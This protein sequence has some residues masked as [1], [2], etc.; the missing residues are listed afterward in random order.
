MSTGC[1]AERGLR[2]RTCLPVNAAALARTL[3]RAGD[4]RSCVWTGGDWQ[5]PRRDV[6]S[7]WRWFTDADVLATV[8]SFLA[9]RH[10]AR[11]LLSERSVCSS[12]DLWEVLVRQVSHAVCAGGVPSARANLAKMMCM[13]P[14]IWPTDET[15]R[16]YILS[17]GLSNYRWCLDLCY[18]GCSVFSAVVPVTDLSARDLRDSESLHRED[19]GHLR[20]V[21]NLLPLRQ[22]PSSVLGPLRAAWSRRTDPVPHSLQWLRFLERQDEFDRDTMKCSLWLFDTRSREVVA[23]VRRDM[24]YGAY[25]GNFRFYVSEEF[26]WIEDGQ[27]VDAYPDEME[28]YVEGRVLEI[29]VRFRFI[30]I[31]AAAY[32]LSCCVQ[33]WVAD[34]RSVQRIDSHAGDDHDLS[35]PA[36]DRELLWE[37]RRATPWDFMHALGA[38]TLQPAVAQADV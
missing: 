34:G 28:S 29:W 26:Q 36:E 31:A 21:R 15:A 10:L 35:N 27:D 14:C 8:A 20:C 17:G 11:F 38:C 2:R 6:N 24:S 25:T 13:T 18:R 4:A 16:G 23:T 7:L 3:P 37:R 33:T 19:S 1:G 30:P 22:L 5:S 9:V 32:Q 12:E